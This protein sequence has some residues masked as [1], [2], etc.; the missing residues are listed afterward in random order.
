MLEQ[1][2]AQGESGQARAAITAVIVQESQRLGLLIGNLLDYAQ[3]EKG[4]RRYT[5]T[6]EAI[7]PLA[8]HAVTT[9]E[10]LRDPPT[11]VGANPPAASRC[12]TRRCAPEVDVDRDVVVGA[13][14]NLLANAVK[15]G[16]G[17]P[18]R[19]PG[20]R[21]RRRCVDRRARSRPRHP[22]PA[23][24]ARIFREFYRAPE[25]YSSGVEGTGL[26]LAL[27]KRHIEAPRVARSRSRHSSAMAPS[28]RSGCR[29]PAPRRPREPR[30]AHPRGRRRPGRSASAS[31]TR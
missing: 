3:I 10:T 13:V 20:R 12:L 26:G 9:F 28:S 30:D 31:R 5:P 2:V 4:T 18:G 7:A 25:A 16:G 1:G 17:R 11:V 29:A 19:G 6:R 23:E 8:R 27:V 22:A 15:Y 14:L 21:R 24:Q